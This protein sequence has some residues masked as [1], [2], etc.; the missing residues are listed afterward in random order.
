LIFKP[1]KTFNQFL[2]KPIKPKQFTLNK[3][4][5]QKKIEYSKKP[6]NKKNSTTNFKLPG[7]PAKKINIR[8]MVVAKLGTNPKSPFINNTT[9]V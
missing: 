3:K 8:I 7:I 9:L 5:K 6:L 4:K 1:N 2:L